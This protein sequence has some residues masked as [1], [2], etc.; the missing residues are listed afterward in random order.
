MTAKRQYRLYTLS[1]HHEQY[2]VVT[3][4]TFPDALARA[5]AEHAESTSDTDPKA[6]PPFVTEWRLKSGRCNRID[7]DLR[8]TASER[9]ADWARGESAIFE[10]R[11][12]GVR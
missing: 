2:H 3:A 4:D 5:R 9:N 11:W 8:L 6:P 7:Y 12:G 10:K 1:A